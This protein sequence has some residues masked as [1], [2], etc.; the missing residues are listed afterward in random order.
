[1]KSCL[2]FTNEVVFVNMTF[3][4]F[5]SDSKVASYQSKYFT[6]QILVSDCGPILAYGVTA[7]PHPIFT[8]PRVWFGMC[9]S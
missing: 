7:K 2:R 6:V 3:D 8:L 5:C 9:K 1:M 4:P